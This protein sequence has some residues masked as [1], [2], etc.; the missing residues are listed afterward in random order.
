VG[1]AQKLVFAELEKKIKE[2]TGR[3]FDGDVWK[4]VE[5]V[6]SL[7]IDGLDRKF[8]DQPAKR[9][10]AEDALKEIQATRAKL[11]KEASLDD[12]FVK[13]L[14]RSR[15]GIPFRSCLMALLR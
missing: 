13:S 14:S 3:T 2:K 10:K 1:E 4:F 12:A 15:S 11:E 7:R 8:L 5:Q 6:D 9:P